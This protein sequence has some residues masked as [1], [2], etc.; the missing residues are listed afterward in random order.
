MTTRV[1]LSR[2][3]V[4]FYSGAPAS[5]ADKW[6]VDMVAQGLLEL[7]SDE[8]G[9]LLYPLA[10][11]KRPARGATELVRC[12]ACQRV[13][14]AATTCG[15]CGQAMDARLRNLKAELADARPQTALVP[16]RASTLYDRGVAVQ[17]QV[18][19]ISALARRMEQLTGS[20]LVSGSPPADEKSLVAAGVFGFFFGP[21]GWIYAGPMREAGVAI[22]ALV[23]ASLLVPTSLLWLVLS[24]LAPVS[25]LINVLYAWQYNRTGVRKSLLLSD[26]NLSDGGSRQ[27]K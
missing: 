17:A 27:T 23:L 20:S 15:R 6:L 9:E 2:T 8:G 21:I 3:N 1:P 10:E 11:G 5:K 7:D 4:V 24:L 25:A 13:T 19:K 16:R 14:G 26:G 12:T 22:R 18:D